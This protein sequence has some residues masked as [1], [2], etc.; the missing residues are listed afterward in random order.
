LDDALLHVLVEQLGV[1]D[2]ITPEVY[3]QGY[4]ICDNYAE[5]ARQI[6]LIGIVLRQ[7]G[8]GARLPVVGM[9]MRL[10]RIPAQRAGWGE[11]YDLLAR[12]YAAFK[13]M[14]DV[15]AFVKTVEQREMRILDRIFAGAPD[16]FAP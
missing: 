9:A 10:A 11:L 6:E 8:E 14:R 16:P 15:K 2:T 4:R 7:V 12:G 3:A 13:P 5:R 1:T